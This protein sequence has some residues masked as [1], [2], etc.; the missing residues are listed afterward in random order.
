MAI[1]QSLAAFGVRQLVDGA[2]STVGLSA[3]EAVVAFL[4]ALQA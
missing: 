3:G 1:Y 4:S 2:L